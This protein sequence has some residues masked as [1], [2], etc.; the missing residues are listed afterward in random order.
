MLKVVLI[1]AVSIAALGAVGIGA[2]LYMRLRDIISQ[3]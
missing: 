2:L 1:A 3:D